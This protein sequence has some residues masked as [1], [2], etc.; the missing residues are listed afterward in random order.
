MGAYI[1]PD[2]ET[3]EAF[4]DREG[5]KVPYEVAKSHSDFKNKFLVALVDNGPFT[6]AAI[7]YDEGERDEFTRP[8][9]TREVQYYLVPKANLMPVSTLDIYIKEPN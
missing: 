2:D 3:K 1:N 9:E 7:A 8:N 4:L 5:I 6:A